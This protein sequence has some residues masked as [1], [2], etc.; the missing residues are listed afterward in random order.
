MLSEFH[1]LLLKQFNLLFKDYPLVKQDVKSYYDVISNLIYL[2][3]P[4]LHFISKENT[5]QNLISFDTFLSQ[6]KNSEKI[7]IHILKLILY[8][9]RIKYKLHFMLGNINIDFKIL[10]DTSKQE[11][12]WYS[13]INDNKYTFKSSYPIYIEIINPVHFHFKHL[14][15][16]NISR[17]KYNYDKYKVLDYFYD[18]KKDSDIYDIMSLIIQS[19]KDEETKKYILDRTSFGKIIQYVSKDEIVLDKEKNLN[20]LI[21]LFI[22]L[23]NNKEELRNA[24][25]FDENILP[26]D[27]KQD[28]VEIVNETNDINV[29]FDKNIILHHYNVLSLPTNLSSSITIKDFNLYKKEK[30]YSVEESIK[31]FLNSLHIIQNYKNRFMD[32]N[33]QDL[34]LFKDIINK[35]K[36]YND[37]LYGVLLNIYSKFYY[38]IYLDTISNE[39]TV[40]LINSKLFDY[41]YRNIDSITIN[42]LVFLKD[43]LIFFKNKDISNGDILK[44]FLYSRNYYYKP[45]YTLTQIQSVLNSN[46]RESLYEVIIKAL[47]GS[48]KD[49]EEFEKK[50]NPI[51]VVLE[52][53]KKDDEIYNRL[54]NFVETSEYTIS[55][56]DIR[57]NQLKDFFQ[58][59]YVSIKDNSNYKYLDFGGADGEICSSISKKLNLTKQNSISIDVLTWFGHERESKFDNITYKYINSNKLHI[60]NESIN[61]ITCFQV[62]HH[63]QHYKDIL[64][65]FHRVLKKGGILIIREHDCNDSYDNMLIDIEHS[66][67]ETTIEKKSIEENRKYLNSYEAFYFSKKE[68][69]ELIKDQYENITDLVNKNL[70]YPKGPTRYYFIILKKI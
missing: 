41:H 29:F 46:H 50:I 39:Q 51:K 21:D 4:E 69:L 30:P 10:I 32:E 63:M 19:I 45:T 11:K 64:N 22:A 28:E 23:R 12:E 35:L 59:R 66:L 62:L 5:K 2:E 20:D 40:N 13:F 48:I 26:Y 25:K 3:T 16:D 37:G 70:F 67:F 47:Y 7:L 56:G 8:L 15:F 49:K 17:I 31:V 1:S 9:Y 57:V 58:S 34:R 44:M 14:I 6:E 65:E 60:E 54:N 55:R 18:M 38:L 68:L 24:I 33:R 27:L 52:R 36:I 43:F 53:Y 61:L 42:Q